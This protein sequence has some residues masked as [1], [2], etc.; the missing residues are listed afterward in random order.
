V[1]PALAL[2][3]VDAPIDADKDV[4]LVLVPGG[5]DTEMLDTPAAGHRQPGRETSPFP[6][7]PSFWGRPDGGVTSTIHRGESTSTWWDEL[8]TV[9]RTY[10]TAHQARDADV[11]RMFE[12]NLAPTDAYARFALGPTLQRRSRH[13]E[14][15]VHFR[16]VAVLDANT[17]D[18]RHRAHHLLDLQK[19]GRHDVLHDQR[20]PPAPGNSDQ[21]RRALNVWGR[22]R[23][24]IRATTD[25]R[26]RPAQHLSRSLW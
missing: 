17:V 25:V 2:R 9:I 14:A 1:H 5:D 15:E 13:D 10:L 11:R 24:P 26:C 7:G 20:S 3:L 12:L 8:P 23:H 16:V 6:A 22:L 19:M 4:D 21:Q 18:H